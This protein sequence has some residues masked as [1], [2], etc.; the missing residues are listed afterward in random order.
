MK[1][2]LYPMGHTYYRN[3]FLTYMSNIF[4]IVWLT[5]FL[6]HAVCDDVHNPKI[7]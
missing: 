6:K 7:K 4:R 3:F 1:N 2:L 5:G